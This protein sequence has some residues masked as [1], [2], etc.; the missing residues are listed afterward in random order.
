MNK[1]LVGVIIVVAVVLVGFAIVKNSKT[2]T[3]SASSD[4]AS[5]TEAMAPNTVVIKNFAFQPS[6]LSIKPGTTVTWV[7]EDSAGHNV[8]SAAFSS[9]NLSNGDTF[10]F[11]FNNKGTFTYNCGIHPTMIGTIVVE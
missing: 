6:P 2:P 11:T 9:Q 7:N 3:N 8:K 1:T 10:E 5:P 4:Q